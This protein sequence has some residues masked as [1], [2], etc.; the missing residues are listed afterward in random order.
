MKPEDQD[1]LGFDGC[2]PGQSSRM[3]NEHVRCVRDVNAEREN[4]MNG[5]QLRKVLAVWATLFI[6]PDD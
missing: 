1:K 2:E 3:A 5:F 4:G 6:I